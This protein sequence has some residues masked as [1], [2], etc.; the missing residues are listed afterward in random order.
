MDL[1]HR[2]NS[3]FPKAPKN[4]A[5]MTSNELK[6]KGL[7]HHAYFVEMREDRER[8]AQMKKRVLMVGKRNQ[9]LRSKVK[10]D[11]NSNGPYR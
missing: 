6:E 1:I 4:P 8:Y 11:I 3:L 2:I 9:P 5:N 7:Y 10:L